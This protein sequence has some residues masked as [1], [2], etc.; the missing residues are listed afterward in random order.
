MFLIS[1]GFVLK[2]TILKYGYTS[3]NIY[4]KLVVAHELN[5]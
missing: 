5:F 2:T 1:K 4:E 3:C